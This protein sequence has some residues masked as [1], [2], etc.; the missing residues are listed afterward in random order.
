VNPIKQSEFIE[1][2]QPL[3]D[4]MELGVGPENVLGF[5]W[6]PVGDALGTWR[7]ALEVT[8]FSYDNE[9]KKSGTI[10]YTRMLARG[11]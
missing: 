9:G 7:D 5:R 1:A 2:L 6:V 3:L 11:E 4:L 8:V 10:T